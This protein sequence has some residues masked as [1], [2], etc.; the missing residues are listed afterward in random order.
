A[1]GT[2]SA[3]GIEDALYNAFLHHER[4]LANRLLLDCLSK[5]HA[6]EHGNIVAMRRPVL[7]ML[8]RLTQLAFS[9]GADISV[10]AA[11]SY[12]SLQH[13]LHI[14]SFRDISSLL[15]KIMNVFFDQF[16]IL[17]GSKYSELAYPCIEYVLANYMRRVPL[18]EVSAKAFMS[19]PYFSRLFKRFM[20]CNYNT[21]VN[22]MRVEWFK[23]ILLT[24]NGSVTDIAN[25]IG[26]DDQSYFTKVFKTCNNGVTPAKYKSLLTS[27]KFYKHIDTSEQ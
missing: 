7:V 19:P 13:I 9:C 24:H 5:I 25:L 4:P 15:I 23:L 1:A 14:K 8:I 20:R 2:Q 18:N 21:Y 27:G 10:F 22:H 3:D 16:T 26:F 6:T 11:T 12:A 17:P